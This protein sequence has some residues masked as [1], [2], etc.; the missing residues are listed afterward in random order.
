MKKFIAKSLQYLT[1]LVWLTG[2]A[3][4]HR[5]QTQSSVTRVYTVPDGGGFYVDGQYYNQAASFIWPAGSKHTLSVNAL[6]HERQNAIYFRELGDWRDHPH[7]KSSN[8]Y[9][10]S[11]Y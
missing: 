3:P 5:A 2:L 10:G 11:F 8:C 4:L 7:A 9:R 6:I 1:V